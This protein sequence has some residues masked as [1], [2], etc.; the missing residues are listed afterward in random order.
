[1]QIKLTVKKHTYLGGVA[2]VSVKFILNCYSLMTTCLTRLTRGFLDFEMVSCPYQLSCR[3]II[4]AKGH[5]LNALTIRQF[6]PQLKPAQCFQILRRFM[7]NWQS[8][9]QFGFQQP[10]R[11]TTSILSYILWT[12]ARITPWLVYPEQ[13]FSSRIYS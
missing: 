6:P 10:D 8:M 3:L 5:P 11:P 12:L 4:P 7:S 2:G 9:L 13:N 1:L